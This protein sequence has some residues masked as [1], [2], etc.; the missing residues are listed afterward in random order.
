MCITSI[1]LR[2]KLLQT[3]WDWG[4][5]AKYAFMENYKGVSSSSFRRLDCASF[6]IW[7][8][9]NWCICE[10]VNSSVPENLHITETQNS[11]GWKGLRKTIWSN[12]IASWIQ[13][14]IQDLTAMLSLDS[15]FCSVSKL[16]NNRQ[17]WP[18]YP[19][20]SSALML[21]LM[22]SSELEFEDTSQRLLLSDRIWLRWYREKCVPSTR[23][24]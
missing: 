22:P 5:H 1:W 6:S 19:A 12:P 13:S 17:E 7:A 11:P 2:V 16:Q 10:K 9:I 18:P 20:R 24:L 21:L 8:Q 4:C 3:G 23:C 14:S 15:A